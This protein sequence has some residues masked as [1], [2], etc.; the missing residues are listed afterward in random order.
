MSRVDKV[1]KNMKFAIL[2]QI[3]SVAVNFV[4][5]K[6][7]VG[8]LGEEYLG[9]NGLFADILSMLSLAEL[10]FGTSIIFSLYKPVAEG[11]T[12][13]IK[14]LMRLYRNIYTAVGLFVL[15]AGAA[16]VPRLDLF[17]KEMPDIAHIRLI[18]L[19]NVFNTAVSYFFAYKAS[20]LFADQK[21]Y[22]EL[23]INTLV[24]TVCAVVQI[25]TLLTVQNYILYL[26]IMIV[27]TVVQ[28]F[29]ISYQTDKR[30]PYLKEKNVL[31]LEKS[32]KD[33][34]RTNVGAMVFHKFGG[35]VIFSTDSILT[36][37]L[38]S[39][40]TVGLYSNYMLIRKA[41]IL[42]IETMFGGITSGMGQLNAMESDEKKFE[43]FKNIFFFSSWLFGFCSICL[44]ELYNPFITLWLGEKYLF[45]KGVVLLIVVYFYMYC[46][47]IPV[48]SS[49]EA[50]GLFKY[51]KNKPIPEA[52][53]NLV[54]S[55]VLA[56]KIGIAGIILGTILSTVFVPLW[57]EP[58]V[59]Y[60]HGFKKNVFDFFA[61]YGVYTLATVGAWCVTAFLCGLTAQG[62]GGF[63]V[64]MLICATVPNVLFLL[65]SFRTR[66]FAY[67]KSVAFSM[68][69][70]FV[71][72]FAK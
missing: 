52:I 45:D 54:L 39:V 63:I 32:D 26:L 19:L 5:R 8:T 37:K 17:V 35:V 7:F 28:N 60:R 15:V 20:L 6:V 55:I 51:D 11:N 34:I 16:L 1:A 2:C 47:R 10:G 69:G 59:V 29:L 65:L 56:K 14:S 44:A 24:K 23:I 36:A 33:T 72:C 61:R 68:L 49:K 42:V 25:V 41:V 18:Y 64:K 67:L 31:P 48:A 38:I 13:K 58:L 4:L 40:A 46:M 62:W 9:L 43:A 57:I 12:E 53:L 22:V 70:K 50:M 30:Y 27:G 66:E 21:K 71:R 3:A